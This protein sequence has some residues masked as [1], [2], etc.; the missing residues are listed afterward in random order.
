MKVAFKER[1]DLIQCEALAVQL[2]LTYFNYVQQVFCSPIVEA[3]IWHKSG[4]G[5]NGNLGWDVSA[6]CSHLE[7][8]YAIKKAAKNEK[9][10]K[11]TT[12]KL[13]RLAMFS[14]A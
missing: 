4:N 10:Q 6:S 3:A 14:I 2:L 5:R 11:R 9:S 8:W 13:A 7:S 12:L 1:P